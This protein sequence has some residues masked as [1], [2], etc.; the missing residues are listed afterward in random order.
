MR[1]GKLLRRVGMEINILFG[2]LLSV[3]ARLRIGQLG[4]G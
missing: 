1:Y 3:H 4:M 2:L